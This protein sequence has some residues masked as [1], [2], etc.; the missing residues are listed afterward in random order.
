[1][2]THKRSE[3]SFESSAG[4]WELV[5]ENNNDEAATATSSAGKNID[6]ENQVTDRQLKRYRC[7]FECDTFGRVAQNAGVKHSVH[8]LTLRRELIQ[9]NDFVFN[10]A[11]PYDLAVTNQRSSGRC[12]MF[13]TLNLLRYHAV[14]TLNVPD[15]EFS[16]AFLFFYDKLEKANAFLENIMATSS[17]D[18]DDRL[19]QMLISD[20]AGDGNDWTPAVSLIRKYGLVPKWAFPESILHVQ[21]LE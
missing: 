10:K 17:R 15:I 5:N 12:W 4:G 16:E 21:Q 6:D 3:V 19:V 1:M 18:M 11:L 20:P 14:E 13:A 7:L 2:K 8:E 9:S